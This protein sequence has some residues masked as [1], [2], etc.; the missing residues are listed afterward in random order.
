MQQL[1]QQFHC[2]TVSQPCQCLRRPQ[3]PSQS[4]LQMPLQQYNQVHWAPQPACQHN[5]TIVIVQA[6]DKS[7][8]TM[9]AFATR[10]ACQPG[11]TGVMALMP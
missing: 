4:A 8:T 2:V 3:T 7:A 11:G 9:Y 1:L 5:E 10:I 6:Q